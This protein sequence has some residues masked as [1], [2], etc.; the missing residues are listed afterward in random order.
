MLDPNRNTRR[1]FAENMMASF[2]IP[3]D[4]DPQWKHYGENLKELNGKL[5]FYDAM[6][7]NIDQSASTA[8]RSDDGADKVLMLNSIHDPSRF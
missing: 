1:E 4:A 2:Q 8:T 7:P 3:D 6:K 5:A